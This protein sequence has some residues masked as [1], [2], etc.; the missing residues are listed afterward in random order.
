MHML[1]FNQS[2]SK[3]IRKPSTRDHSWGLQC[4]CTSTFP[5]RS[6]VISSYIGSVGSSVLQF[7]I[8]NYQRGVCPQTTVNG[9]KAHYVAFQGEF[10]SALRACLILEWRSETSLFISESQALPS[11][12]WSQSRRGQGIGP[13]ELG[14]TL[15]ALSWDAVGGPVCPSSP[16][17]SEA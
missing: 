4:R 16:E 14:H 1:F 6:W 2:F 9:T 11:H 13:A 12:V 8:V 7:H 17:G 5:G 15:E 3:L 10:L